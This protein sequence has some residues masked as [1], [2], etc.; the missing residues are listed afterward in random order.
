M[1]GMGPP[2]ERITPQGSGQK[3]EELL[4]R[5]RSGDMSAHSINENLTKDGRTITCEW[6]NT[7]L[8]SEDGLFSGLMCLA[9]DVTERTRT[10]RAVPPGPKD[11]SYRPTGGRRRP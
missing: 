2:F 3:A 8:E 5:I 4:R 11:G 7:P 9:Q 1:L 6:I 10:G